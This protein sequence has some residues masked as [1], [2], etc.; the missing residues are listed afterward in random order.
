MCRTSSRFPLHQSC[1]PRAELLAVV[2]AGG[3]GGAG[4]AILLA[5]LGATSL[6]G[7]GG[8]QLG[9]ATVLLLASTLHLDEGEDCGAG[10]RNGLPHVAA[11]K[12]NVTESY[13][14]GH[15]D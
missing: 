7:C 15:Q 6:G 3:L 9:V 4:V 12:Q 5:A 2:R 10:L 11:L 14:N 13:H 8:R 1:P